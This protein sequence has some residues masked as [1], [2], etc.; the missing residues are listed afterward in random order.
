MFRH[1]DKG[2]T[3]AHNLQLA[4]ILSA[5]AGIVNISGVLSLTTLTTNVTGHFAYLSQ[6]LIME[7]YATALTF[8]SYITF[9]LAGAFLSSL[10]LEWGSR[11][12]LHTSYARP[13]SI[14]IVILALIGS[15]GLFPWRDGLPFPNLLAGMLLFA[16]GLQ[17]ALV[18][19]VSQSVVRTTHLTGLLTDLGIELSQ[20]FFYKEKQQRHQLHKSISLKL[21]IIGCFLLGGIVGGF[22]YLFAGLKVLYLPVALLLLALGRQK[23]KVEGNQS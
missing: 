6:A 17:N 23:L 12:K 18:T 9:F 7:N 22:I 16:M 10:L 20:L 4:S 5:V 15:I 3:Y 8:L 2:R 11:N 13:V 1:K 19:H 14:E 21:T